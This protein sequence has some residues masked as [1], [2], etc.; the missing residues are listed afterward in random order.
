[1]AEN[2][3]ILTRVQQETLDAIQRHISRTGKSPTLKE[4]SITLGKTVASIAD[5]IRALKRKGFIISAPHRWRN[6]ELREHVSL[7]DTRLVEIPLFGSVGADNLSVIANYEFNQFLRIERSLLKGHRDVFS[8]RVQGNSMRDAGI[9]S[10]DYVLAEE[11]TLGDVRDGETVVAISG[12][13]VV[14]KRIRKNR[15]VVILEPVN[16]SPEYKSIVI[17]KGAEDFRVIGRFID[18]IQFKKNDEDEDD[19]VFEEI[20]Q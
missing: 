12:D 14:L 5:R 20:I 8:V 9:F 15:D 11:A 6:I 3:R 4:L 10:G 2:G 17:K 13:M 7:L 1:M 18:V 19:V 16:A